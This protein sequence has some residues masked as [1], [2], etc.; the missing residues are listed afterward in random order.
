MKM[1]KTEIEKFRAEF[2]AAVAGLEERYGVKVGIGNIKYTDMDFHTTLTVK[3]TVNE[4]GSDIDLDKVEFEKYCWMFGLGKDDY[5]KEV[6]LFGNNTPYIV[7]GVNPNASK[8]VIRIK[9]KG[10]GKKYV[11]PKTIIREFA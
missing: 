6:H 8:N 11:C 3:N 9:D 4:D 5:L 1:N 7:Y 10:T 2:A